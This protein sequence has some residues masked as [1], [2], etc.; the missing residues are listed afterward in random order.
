MNSQISDIDQSGSALECS[1]C[2]SKAVYRQEDGSYV[3]AVCHA[4][5]DIQETYDEVDNLAGQLNMS[6]SIKIT[7]KED[8]SENARLNN[9]VLGEAL[10]LILAS[11]TV[12]LEKFLEIPISDTVFYYLQKFSNLILPPINATTFPNML[13][14]LL[15]AITHIGIPATHIDII[16]WIRDGNIPYYKPLTI[17]PTSFTNLLSQA[18]KDKL[19][20]PIINLNLL[21]PNRD[22]KTKTD[23]LK[24]HPLPNA[25]LM[26]WRIASQIGLPER[27]FVS[28]C[29]SLAL[30][31]PLDSVPNLILMFSTDR[32]KLYSITKF[33]RVGVA[34]P[35]ALA[36]FGLSLIYRLDGTDWINPH[37]SKLGFPKFSEILKGPLIRSEVM[38][39]FPQIKGQIPHLHNDLA[40]LLE[41]DDCAQFEIS[42]IVND[43]N[44]GFSDECS[45]I[46]EANSLSEMNNDVKVLI[47]GLSRY[48]GVSQLLILQQFS[49]L[50]QKRFGLFFQKKN[51]NDSS[52]QE[53][54]L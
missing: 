54:F 13:L 7:H 34:M 17:L 16:R 15:S 31:K 37:F 14:I 46:S 40:R 21:L 33:M 30:S 42:T 26:L 48:F 12:A 9:V 50:I 49:H 53:P 23:S 28:F 6:Y 39:S 20:P 29:I 27:Q 10:Q 35:I 41:N 38:P 45:I 4:I 3:C 5:Q 36:I 25:K 18:E 44:I 2:F 32:T 11:Q 8:K 43:V 51:S 22:S 19:D 24:I 47:A 1:N 52:Q